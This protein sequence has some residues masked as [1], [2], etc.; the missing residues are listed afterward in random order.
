[1]RPVVLMSVVCAMAIGS[2]TAFGAETIPDP[3]PVQDSV[4]D[5]PKVSVYDPYGMPYK[6]FIEHVTRLGKWYWDHGR[7]KESM[8]VLY[9]GVQDKSVGTYEIH[10]WVPSGFKGLQDGV[11]DCYYDP[12]T[13]KAVMSLRSSPVRSLPMS[14]AAAPAVAMSAPYIASTFVE[15]VQGV[16]AIRPFQASYT[17]PHTIAPLA[18]AYNATPQVVGPAFLHTLTPV[19]HA[20]L[21]GITSIAGCSSYG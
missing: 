6:D 21:L 9:V 5:P 17:T 8:G 20:G 19:R 12:V 11:Y 4:P 16:P 7:V 14:A 18:A 15:P 3:P 2:G 1:M 10:C 13:T